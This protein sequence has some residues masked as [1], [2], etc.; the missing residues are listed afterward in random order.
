MRKITQDGAGMRPRC[1]RA[2]PKITRMTPRCPK[3]AP[4]WSQDGPDDPNVAPRW[5]Q[6]GPRWSEDAQDVPRCAQD[7]PIIAEGGPKT[8]TGGPRWISDGPSK[9]VGK[10]WFLLVFHGSGA[11]EGPKMAPGCPRWRQDAVREFQIGAKLGRHH[12]KVVPG[13]SRESPR[14][15]R[16]GP[17]SDLLVKRL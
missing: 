6:G 5:L 3:T 11:P 4:S 10:R 13:W 14:R 17:A 9:N 16:G 2:D 7:S 15:T 1:A 8:V 12:P